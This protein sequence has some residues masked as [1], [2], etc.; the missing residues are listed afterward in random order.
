MFCKYNM[1][2]ILYYIAD[3]VSLLATR[4]FFVEKANVWLL[5]ATVGTICME[6]CQ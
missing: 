6:L 4:N 3:V 1:T 2:T 5:L